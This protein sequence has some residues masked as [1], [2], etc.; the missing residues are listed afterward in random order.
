M[1]CCGSRRYVSC[2]SNPHF[3]RRKS[4][5]CHRSVPP[6]LIPSQINR[7]ASRVW[8]SV[9]S[10]PSPQLALEPLTRLIAAALLRHDPVSTSGRSGSAGVLRGRS[11]PCIRHTSKSSKEASFSDLRVGWIRNRPLRREPQ[12]KTLDRDH[13]HKRSLS[14]K[15]SVRDIV[16]W[17]LPSPR[18]VCARRSI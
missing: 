16:R 6:T 2:H 18:R 1:A 9:P 7:V 5:I 17:A 14:V 10:M 12:P 3:S 4:F 8:V 11:H 15:T 13:R